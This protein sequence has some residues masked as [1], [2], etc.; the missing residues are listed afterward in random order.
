LKSHIKTL[1]AQPINEKNNNKC[2]ASW[3]E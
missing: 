1:E 2:R 3:H